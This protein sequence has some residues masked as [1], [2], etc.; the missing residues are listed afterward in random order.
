MQ[1]GSAINPF[2]LAALSKF[3]CPKSF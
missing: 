3:S 1:S 2:A